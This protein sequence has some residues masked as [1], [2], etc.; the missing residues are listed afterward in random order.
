MNINCSFSGSVTWV[1]NKYGNKS[2][3]TFV[4]NKHYVEFHPVTRVH[5]G[6]YFCIGRDNADGSALLS[7][8][9]LQVYGM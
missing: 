7:K 3:L 8:I 2:D 6:F 5:N 9:Q 4:S 1:F